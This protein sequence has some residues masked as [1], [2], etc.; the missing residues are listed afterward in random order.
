MRESRIRPLLVVIPLLLSIVGFVLAM[1]A[2]FAG[3]GPQQQAME[4]YHL[5]AINM[6]NFGHDLIA[7]A[8]SSSPEPTATGDGSFWDDIENGLNDIGDGITDGLNDI[9][10][11]YADRLAEELG[12]SQWYSL[13][14][15]TACEGDFAPN[16]TTPGAWYNTTNCTTQQPG[17][18]L[19]LTE[20]LTREID[21]GPL[22]INVA[23]IPLP[24]AI[25]ETVE[26]LNSFLLALFILYVLGSGFSG[27]SFLG[28]V[29]ALTLR[30]RRSSSSNSNSIIGV[31]RG[32]MLA[33][34]ALA[35]LAAL[36]LA[37]GSAVATAVSR[38]GVAEI[39]ER[40]AGAGVS[41]IPGEKFLIVSWVA[42]AVMFVTLLFWTVPCCLP[43]TRGG[44]GAARSSHPVYDSAE[45]GARV[46]VGGGG[47][48]GGLLGFFGRRR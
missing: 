11:D 10:N 24:D 22:D 12:I 35:G 20:V 2:L 48:R 8:T 39:N 4:D 30:H 26:Y 23:D 37:I 6:S 3:T 47:R 21:A 18:Q 38:R 13:H 46:G 32:A 28:A 41:A 15:M 1:L 43:R 16:A 7:S 40:G 9:A 36:A 5:I 17:V 25:A 31:G 29:V 14:I 45:K 34:G 42:F 27:L 33:N 44:H 19:N